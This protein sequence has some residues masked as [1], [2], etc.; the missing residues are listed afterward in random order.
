MSRSFFLLLF[1]YSVV[2]YECAIFRQTRVKRCNTC[3]YG[4]GFYPAGKFG[5]GYFGGESYESRQFYQ[6]QRFGGGYG[7][8]GFGGGMG[9]RPYGPMG[10]GPRGRMGMGPMGR[11]GPRMPPPP[12]PPPPAPAYGA[13]CQTGCQGGMVPPVGAASSASQQELS[14]ST[15]FNLRSGAA[16]TVIGR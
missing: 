13:P 2:V 1:F 9:M 7:G 14:I 3:G 4:G 5:R 15:N 10:M 8:G 6:S 16:S 12:P 11:F